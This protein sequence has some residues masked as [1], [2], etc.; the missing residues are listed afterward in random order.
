MAVSQAFIKVMSAT[1]SCWYRLTGGLIGGNVLGAPVLLLITTGRKSARQR[2]T[3]L[4]YLRDDQDMVIVAS[5]GGNDRHP[6]WWLNLEANPQAEVQVGSVTKK[7]R[8]ERAKQ[9]ERSRL[10][11]LLVDVYSGYEGYQ[12][13][14]PS[15]DPQA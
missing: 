7:V 1:H 12:A 15:G 6:A 4:L 8:A 11:P 14:N 9:K 2:T 3:P 13:R 10:W 5:N